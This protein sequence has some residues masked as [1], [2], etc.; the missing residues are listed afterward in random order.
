MLFKQSITA[1]QR[2]T[3]MEVSCNVIALE[4]NFKVSQTL[5]IIFTTEAPTVLI[6]S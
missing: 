5:E 6:F 2:V 3:H 1:H 4:A